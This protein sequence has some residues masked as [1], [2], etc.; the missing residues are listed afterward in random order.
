[1]APEILTPT[2]QVLLAVIIIVLMDGSS[3]PVLSILQTDIIV[4]TTIVM[5]AFVENIQL[6]E[7]ATLSAIPG[8][9]RKEIVVFP[10]LNIMSLAA[11]S[12][13]TLIGTVFLV[14]PK[15]GT[16]GVG[17]HQPHRPI[18][19][20]PVR[21]NAVTNAPAIIPGTVVAVC[22][23]H[24]PVLVRQSLAV[25]RLSGTEFPATRRPGPERA[26]IIIADRLSITPI[27]PISTAATNAPM[28]TFGKMVAVS[29]PTI[30]PDDVR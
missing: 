15:L 18:T 3:R 30:A 22:L 21:P 26:G 12:Q 11:P 6:K 19:Q 1:M 27:P 25:L 28:V 23:P 24:R 10:I 13:L 20:L 16:G 5:K 9:I 4:M 29:K 14:S 8:F 7:V 2:S 17:R